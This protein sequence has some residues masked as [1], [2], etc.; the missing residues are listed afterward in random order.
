METLNNSTKARGVIN[1]IICIALTITIGQL[2]V[3]QPITQQTSSLLG[4]DN[5]KT[6]A[7][8]TA[9]LLSTTLSM[10]ITFFIGLMISGADKEAT[11]GFTSNPVS[12]LFCYIGFATWGIGI[13]IGII[14]YLQNLAS[15]I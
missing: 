2:I 10:I 4:I 12:R 13:L 1:V 14:S 7:F 5:L 15:G 6:C 8:L 9:F 3:S 11:K